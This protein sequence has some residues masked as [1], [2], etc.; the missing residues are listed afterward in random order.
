MKIMDFKFKTNVGDLYL[1]PFLM[2][3][4]KRKGRKKWGMVS[5]TGY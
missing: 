2:I 5:A 3:L 1:L 4:A